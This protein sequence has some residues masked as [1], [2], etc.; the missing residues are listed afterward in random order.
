M[1]VHQRDQ[2]GITVAM[3]ADCAGSADQALHVGVL[4]RP[5][6]ARQ[7]FFDPHIAYPSPEMLTINAA[8]MAQQILGLCIPRTGI[9][10]LLG[11]P[12]RG[13][14]FGEIDM[15]DPRIALPHCLDKSADLLGN[16]GP[17][18]LATLAQSPLVLPEPLL[19]PGHEGARLAK[20]EPG[21]PF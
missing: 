2:R 15:H 21:L 11:R 12:L 19:L 18:G 3:P 16:R 8:P 17:A 6:K 10:H 1:P 14:I 20:G 4:A 5:P 7:H 9:H 13:E